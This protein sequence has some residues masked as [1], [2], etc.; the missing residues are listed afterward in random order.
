MPY[1]LVVDGQLN[2]DTLHRGLRVSE[3]PKAAVIDLR[4]ATFV[5]P[6]GMLAI[7]SFAHAAMNEG[8]SV[9]LLRPRD[10]NVA[11]YLSRSRLGL[12]LGAVGAKHDLFAV[13]EHEVG[14]GL[15]EVTSFTNTMGADVLAQHVERVASKTDPNTARTIYMAIVALGENVEAHSEQAYGYAAAQQLQE[16][17]FFAVAD[18]GVGFRHA[19]RAHSPT[20]DSAALELA[21]QPGISGL[22]ETSRGFGLEE[23][24]RAIQK[25]G[26]S[27]RLRSGTGAMDVH[28]DGRLSRSDRATSLAGSVLEGS[29]P[30]GLPR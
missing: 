17:F 15:L 1:D 25:L 27:F 2:V 26:G 7:V 12:R 21:L 3:K 23:L 8:R 11:R 13:Q 9:R 10:L 18:P 14:L 30:T 20:T 6:A 29:I 19:L 24:K 22:Q 28:P 4:G 16:R 5:T